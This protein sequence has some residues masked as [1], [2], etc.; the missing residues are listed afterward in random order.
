MRL[1]AEWHNARA[2]TAHQHGS[3]DRA[4][5]LYEKA[6]AED[7]SWSVPWYNLG[8]LYKERH[9]WKASLR[10]NQEAVCRDPSNEPAWWNLGIAATALSDWPEARRAWSACGIELPKGAG[11]IRGEFCHA[12]IRI[13]PQTAGE[14]VWTCR[15]DPARAIVKS[16]PLP[17]SG[18]RHGDL[19]LHDGAPKGYRMSRGREV[20]VFDELEILT[21]SDFGTFETMVFVETADDLA[22]LERIFD[23]GGGAAEDWSS[24][25]LI[26][27]QCDRA[28]P[29]Q[30][31]DPSEV[32]AAGERRIGLAA[33]SEELASQLIEA[34]VAENRSRKS[35][36]LVTILSPQ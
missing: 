35:S 26:C 12:P 24:A 1:V 10:C 32:H 31:H 15:I 7:S 29:H 3:F 11:E 27:E 17:E 2:R 28:R 18:H 5:S 8:L 13:N 19:L 21:P 33:S 34:W 22:A 4:V 25:R 9:N 36:S 16:V 20:P 23:A 30:G 14:V 6:I